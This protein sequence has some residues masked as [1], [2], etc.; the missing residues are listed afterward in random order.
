MTA[1]TTGDDLL[2][3]F[4]DSFA[5]RVRE[6]VEAMEACGV[7][8]PSTLRVDGGLTRSPYLMQRQADA[9]GIPVEVAFDDE[10]TALGV[11]MMA[12]RAF[13]EETFPTRLGQSSAVFEPSDVD[14]TD[15]AYRL[16]R[17]RTGGSAAE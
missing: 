16:W 14:E 4:L 2:H 13:G 9:L 17:D 15:R 5:F 12:R 1:A 10:A 8:R 7:P 3:G 11:A 6:I